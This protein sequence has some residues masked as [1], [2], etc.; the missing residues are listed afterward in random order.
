MAE[1]TMLPQQATHAVPPGSQDEQPPQDDFHLNMPRPRRASAASSFRSLASSTQ[2]QWYEDSPGTSAEGQNSDNSMTCQRAALLPTS[3]SG[4]FLVSLAGGQPQALV[5]WGDLITL[6]LDPATTARLP[7]GHLIADAADN[8]AARLERDP[9]AFPFVTSPTDERH[10]AAIAGQMNESPSR[11]FFPAALLSAPQQPTH[12]N[13]QQQPRPHAL[14]AFPSFPTSQPTHRL[15]DPLPPYSTSCVNPVHTVGFAEASATSEDAAAVL[16]TPPTYFQNPPHLPSMDSS[17]T[18]TSRTFAAG[19][20]LYAQSPGRPSSIR[21]DNASISSRRS[22]S[23]QTAAQSPYRRPPLIQTAHLSASSLH[24]FAGAMHPGAGS[25]LYHDNDL[26]EPAT[27]VPTELSRLT[28]TRGPGRGPNRRIVKPLNRD[29]ETYVWSV[30]RHSLT[31]IEPGAAGR[32]RARSSGETV[33]VF[34]PGTYCRVFVDETEALPCDTRNRVNEWLRGQCCVEGCTF[35]FEGKRPSVIRQH[36]T[37]CKARAQIL[38]VDPLKRFC[39]LQL[40]AQNHDSRVRQ[41]AKYSRHIKAPRQ[42]EDDAND[43]SSIFSYESYESSG[44]G[45]GDSRRTSWYNN[46]LPAEA[47]DAAMKLEGQEEDLAMP[48]SEQMH[49]LP[50]PPAD[51][52]EAG[53]LAAEWNAT[54]SLANMSRAAAGGS[55]LQQQQEKLPSPH[56]HFGQ[57]VA[58]SGSASFLSFDD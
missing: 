57:H 27:A 40:D 34:P 47:D 56:A 31:R 26:E 1:P 33:L 18:V 10:F 50:A 23:R 2:S 15:P 29:E 28:N 54:S 53:T 4:G 8:I 22:A 30:L 25:D 49:P 51:W 48:D 42:D 46:E 11:S 17:G 14:S 13:Q 41:T 39:Q 43:R 32:A 19:V 7:S 9:G 38:Q 24:E 5:R 35:R 44:G 58:A 52:T 45:G 3:D 12:Y 36:V 21:S 37:T 16:P 20:G 55:T 6:L